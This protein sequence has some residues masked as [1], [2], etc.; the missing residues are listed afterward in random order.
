MCSWRELDSRCNNRLAFCLLQ[1]APLLLILC[2]LLCY[3]SFRFRR[4]RMEAL[5]AK[6]PG[7]PAWPLIGNAL[8]F[9]GSSHGKG[10]YSLSALPC[11]HLILSFVA[12]PLS[13]F[14]LCLVLQI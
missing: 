6:L 14:V 12:C 5:A 13:I 3:M 11:F 2:L 10:R 1:M 9:L 4:R 7:P 8:Q